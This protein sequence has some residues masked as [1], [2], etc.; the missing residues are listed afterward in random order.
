MD[1][2]K[3][4]INTVLDSMQKNGRPSTSTEAITLLVL[5]LQEEKLL[6]DSPTDAKYETVEKQVFELISDDVSRYGKASSNG[7]GAQRAFNVL[8]DAGLLVKV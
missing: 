8:N 3:K 2:K 4:V 5:C 1:V 7:M 6:V